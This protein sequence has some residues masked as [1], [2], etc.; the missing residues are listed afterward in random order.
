M[1]AQRA[2]TPPPIAKLTPGNKRTASPAARLARV[3]MP[4]A[5]RLADLVERGLTAL[6]PVVHRAV[7]AVTEALLAAAVVIA[8]PA[9]APRVAADP[10]AWEAGAWVAAVVVEVAVAG[11]IASA[12]GSRRE[13][14]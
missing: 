13:T 12:M 14:K 6:E 4:Q 10:P 5:V 3:L 11:E 2:V 8:V 9:P 7:A 1:A